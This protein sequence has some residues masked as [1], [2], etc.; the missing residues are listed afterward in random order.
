MQKC[1]TISHD[2]GS[3]EGYVSDQKEH[4]LNFLM[5][6]LSEE[7]AITTVNALYHEKEIN[8][9][10]ILKNVNVEESARNQGIG[11][12]LVCQ[13]LDD[14]LTEEA[15]V[16]LLIAD[17]YESNTMNLVQWYEGFDFDKMRETSA[18]MLMCFD[19]N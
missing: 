13:F 3:A 12:D 6:Y 4:M 14:A 15:D 7:E 9:F 2:N 18:G 8:S 10:A 1:V 11:S 17:Q 19:Y 5:N 16:C